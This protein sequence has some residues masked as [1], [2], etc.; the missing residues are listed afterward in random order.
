LTQATKCL[1]RSS[2]RWTWAV[3][4]LSGCTLLG[5]LPYDPMESPPQP[6]GHRIKP[7]VGWITTT[8]PEEGG[9]VPDGQ[10]SI[11]IVHIDNTAYIQRVR[12]FRVGVQQYADS[13]LL[14]RST[15]R[16]LET[17]R[18][19][20]KG[21]YITRYNHRIVSRTFRAPNGRQSHS[22][23]TLDVEPFAALGMDLIVA[24]LPLSEGYKGL[25]PVSVDTMPRGWSWLH[26][27]VQ[28]EMTIQERSDQA[29]RQT[30]IIDCDIGPDRTR[31]Y[32]A[33][34][35][36]SVRKMQGLTPDNTIT[37]QIRRMLL[38]MPA[39]IKANH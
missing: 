17:W 31:L 32:V 19:T 23:E 2:L 27:E 20:P 36:R 12:R 7:E 33:T 37:W 13:I 22:V 30:L 14:D 25:L 24:S 5:H 28:R 38:S 16:P 35:G 3:A 29:D 6:D 4:C 11:S 8:R 1:F 15:L 10:T 26:F 39:G 21:T 18:W 9:T 34:D